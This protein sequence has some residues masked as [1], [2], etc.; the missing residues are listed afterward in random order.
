MFICL[1]RAI[2]EKYIAIL[3]S[4]SRLDLENLDFLPKRIGC[5]LAFW[6]GFLGSDLQAYRY[7]NSAD[8]SNGSEDIWFLS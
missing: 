8:K 6:D 7:A 5:K 3:F 1:C 4:R 2:N